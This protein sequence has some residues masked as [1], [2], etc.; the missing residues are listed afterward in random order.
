MMDTFLLYGSYGYTGSLIADLAVKH[1]LKPVISGR[2]TV[3]LEKQAAQLG[4]RYVTL[5]LDDK[6]AWDVALEDLPLVLNCA[7]PFSHTFRPVAEAC[8]R[9][10]R[11]YLDITGEIPVFEALATRD[12]AAKQAEVM[13]LPGVGFDVVPSDC[14]AGHLKRRLPEAT[15]LTIAIQ[16]LGGGSS[17]GTLLTGIDHLAE[18]G[19][20]R[21]DGKMVRVL[22]L[23][24][25]NTFDFGHGP[26][27]ALNIPWGDVSTAYYSTGIPNIETYMV[28]HRRMLRVIPILR[29]FIGLAGSPLVN[30]L[31]R[32]MILRSPAGPTDEQRHTGQSRLIG[33]ASAAAGQQVISKMETP[34]SYQLTA[35]TSVAIVERVL[36]G[37]LTP[38]FQTPARAY[39]PDLIM[40]FEGV[41]R[42][43]L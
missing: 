41:K 7:G 43:D 14:L 4:L 42:V 11:H 13:L 22:L 5:S 40:E 23:G 24:K 20:E 39:G 25:V 9:A 26:Q 2:D 30:R 6:T 19:A 37:E 36:R 16:G 31:L 33:I 28:F 29:S 8:L 27:A 35:V 1:G 10:K 32:W 34:N 21:R 15:Y 3:R 12:H 38:G 17:R 18:G